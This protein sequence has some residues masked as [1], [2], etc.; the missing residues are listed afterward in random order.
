MSG[1]RHNAD[2]LWKT[3]QEG[4]SVPR[5]MTVLAT[6]GTCEHRMGGQRSAD[7][8]WNCAWS[9]RNVG[10]NVRSLWVVLLD[11][12]R[13]VTLP[14][15][16]VDIVTAGPSGRRLDLLQRRSTAGRCKDAKAPR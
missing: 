5:R 16:L 9:S 7:A 11:V 13:Q 4:D 6:T 12:V 2:D 14:S 1:G 15:P 3:S 8:R 10:T